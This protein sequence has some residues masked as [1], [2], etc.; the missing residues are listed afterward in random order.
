[1]LF[2][3]KKYFVLSSFDLDFLGH[4]RAMGYSRRL[5]S[6]HSNLPSNIDRVINR[7]SLTAIH[8]DHRSLSSES[9]I[10]LIKRSGSKVLAWTVN[11]SKRAIELFRMGVDMLIS[12][13][14]DQLSQS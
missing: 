14:P 6:I 7:L 5:A 11:D 4:C 13:F 12:D 2:R 10:T 1:M 9:E 8:I 3:S